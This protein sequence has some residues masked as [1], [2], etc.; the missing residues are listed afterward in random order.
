MGASLLSG[1][2]SGSLIGLLSRC[3]SGLSHL[4]ADGLT[5]P[6]SRWPTL[7][8]GQLVLGISRKPQFLTI[9]EFHTTS[10]M[11]S[12]HGNWLSPEQVIREIERRKLLLFMSLK[13]HT[14]S[15]LQSYLLHRSTLFTEGGNYTRAWIPGG[16]VILEAGEHR[17]IHEL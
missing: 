14:L 13:R 9:W 15:F 7:M 5:H 2:S 12:P 3:Q 11:S 10:L 8:D 6:F 16:R 17:S 4:K 1:S